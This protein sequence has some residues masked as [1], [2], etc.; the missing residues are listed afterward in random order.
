MRDTYHREINYMRLSIT[1]RCN[2]RCTYCMPEGISCIDH[3][4][5]LR[6]E[7]ILRVCQSAIELGITNFKITGGEPLVRKGCL[8][9]IDHLKQMNGVETVTLTTNGILLQKA[10]P[11]LKD[12]GV[13]AINISLDTTE[14]EAYEKLTGYDQYQK[15]KSAVVAC[16]NSG[17]RTKLN[18]VLLE[19]QKQELTKLASF[20]ENDKV[21]VR[22]IELMPIGMG[23]MHRGI[24][25]MQAEK[26]LKK[27]YPDLKKE[28][29][30]TD[31]WQGNGPAVY[32]TSKALKGRI[33]WINAVS[34]Q[35]CDRCNRM[36][37]TST[38]KLKPCLCYGE[39]IDLISILRDPLLDEKNIDLKIREKIEEAINSKPMAHCFRNV[40]QISEKKQ[41][42]QIGG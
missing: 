24:S 2:L 33:G 37:L 30:N 26:I 20:A 1:D 21:D 6:Y 27:K 11:R 31:I 34:H 13:D 32:E 41:M 15:V 3:K 9:F 8:D 16:I 40:N 12:I 42:S 22:F 25:R 10:I 4:D 29:N 38:G 5:I 7:E 35:F 17:I 28:M 39:T 23:T 36:R 14:R 18:C 19:S